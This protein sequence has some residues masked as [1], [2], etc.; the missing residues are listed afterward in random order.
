ML[1][2]GISM[3]IAGSRP[4]FVLVYLIR[5]LIASLF[6]CMCALIASIVDTIL[7]EKLSCKS[8]KGKAVK[9][10]L[11][12][13]LAVSLI[14]SITNLIVVNTAQRNTIAQ[15]SGTRS[16]SMARVAPWQS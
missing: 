3:L 16:T 1:V 14:H 13:T 15:L 12:V 11:T 10:A 6:L 8:D 2:G 4:S 5:L 9:I 7:G